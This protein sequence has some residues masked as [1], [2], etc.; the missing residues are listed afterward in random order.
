MNCPD[1]VPAVID[2]YCGDV[3]PAIS[4]ARVVALATSMPVSRH[5]NDTRELLLCLRCN[6]LSRIARNG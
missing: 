4:F 2:A 1:E 6:N 5:P 3:R